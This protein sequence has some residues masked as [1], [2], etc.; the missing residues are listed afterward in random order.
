MNK[1]SIKWILKDNLITVL[2][3]V[4]ARMAGGK[5]CA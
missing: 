4:I 1:K 5:V 3:H 2:A